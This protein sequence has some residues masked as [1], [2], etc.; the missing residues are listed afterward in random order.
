MTACWLVFCFMVSQP[1]WVICYQS[2]HCRRTA[3]ILF[4]PYIGGIIS[5]LRVLVWKWTQ[6]RDWSWNPLT[7]RPPSSTLAITPLLLQKVTSSFLSN[8]YLT[9]SMNSG[10]ELWKHKKLKPADGFRHSLLE[11]SFPRNKSKINES[12][13][14]KFYQVKQL[15][16][17]STGK[18]TEKNIKE[19]S[20]FNELWNIST[21]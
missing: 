12:R 1:L 15:K 18:F 6:Q 3:G 13:L 14:L 4:N 7:W 21:K 5:F 16:E 19:D 17:N 20:Q 11:W 8:Y 9:L 2:H 10:T